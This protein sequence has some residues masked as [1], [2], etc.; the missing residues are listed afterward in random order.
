MKKIVVIISVFLFLGLGIFGLKHVGSE[1]QAAGSA[2]FFAAEGTWYEDTSG[3]AVVK[4]N[5][6]KK[7]QRES[8]PVSFTIVVN[9]D[10]EG[11]SLRYSPSAGESFS[12][13]VQLLGTGTDRYFR[14][15]ENM[16]FF[17]DKMEAR[18]PGYDTAKL[19]KI[20]IPPE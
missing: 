2:P 5:V 18:R 11:Y 4:R 8:L 14:A 12:E 9:F 15:G 17:I 10:G 13:K 20:V 16:E 3:V 6:Q 7:R 1:A 19:K